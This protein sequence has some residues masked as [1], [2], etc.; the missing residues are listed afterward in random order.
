MYVFNVCSM[1]RERGTQI[2]TNGK[3]KAK[4]S[5]FRGCEVAT[6]KL[7]VCIYNNSHLNNSK[8][9]FVADAVN[10]DTITLV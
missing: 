4:D 5:D 6:H 8:I 10:F 2:K 1:S 7:L 9:L 3:D